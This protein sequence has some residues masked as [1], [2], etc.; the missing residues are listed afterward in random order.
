VKVRKQAA[1]FAMEEGIPP[2]NWGAVREEL[3][4]F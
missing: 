2:E 1:L 3:R 4:R